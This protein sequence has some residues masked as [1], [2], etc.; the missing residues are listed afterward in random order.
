MPVTR[1]EAPWGFPLEI[2]SDKNI[3]VLVDKFDCSRV[4]ENTIRIVV[5]DEPICI[6]EE[7]VK[8][9]PMCY[10][11]VFTFL[12][13]ILD[14]NPKAVFFRGIYRW[15]D[16]TKAYPKK[17]AVSTVVGAKDNPVFEGYAKRHELWRRRGEIKIPKDF[18][19]S[20]TYKPVGVDLSHELI[21]GDGRWDKEQMFDCMFHICIENTSI[22]NYFS[23]KILDCFLTRTIPIYCGCPNI[24]D[25]FNTSSIWRA[26]DVDEIIDYT[27]VMS[28][29]IYN[30]LIPEITENYFT[31]LKYINWENS[32]KETILK[33]L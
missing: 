16:H 19:L 1:N 24:Y 25:F 22:P 17:F 9:Y 20:H 18:Y 28:E 12:Q 31:A 23:E 30:V 7:D 5:M 21:L 29:R 2:E 27:N 11:Y 8:N 26:D 15:V 3:E 33:L 32:L 13:D 10:T 4:P 14:T 6:I